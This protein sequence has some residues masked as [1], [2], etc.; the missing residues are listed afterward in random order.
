MTNYG[1]QNN[2][3]QICP[4]LILGIYKYIILHGR[5]DLGDVIKLGFRGYPG[6]LGE[7]T[8]ITRSLEVE[9]GDRA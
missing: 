3:P 6:L 5:R 2:R 9:Q 7:S 1:K 4:H 8:V